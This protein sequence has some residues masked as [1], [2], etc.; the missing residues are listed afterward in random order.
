MFFAFKNRIARILIVLFLAA[1]LVLVGYDQLRR[2]GERLLLQ[3]ASENMEAGNFQAGLQVAHRAYQ[4][5]PD[6]RPAARLMAVML[7]QVEPQAALPWWKRAWELMPDDFEAYTRILT[8]SMNSAPPEEVLERINRAPPGFQEKAEF[9][10]LA[11]LVYL[12]YQDYPR[13]LNA[14][15]RAIELDPADDESRLGQSLIRSQSNRPDEA[16]EAFRQILQ[17]TEPG[18]P[19]EAQA[20]YNL[21]TSNLNARLEPARIA[22][23]TD[24]YLGLPTTDFAKRLEAVRVATRLFPSKKE[25]WLRVLEEEAL[26]HPSR[27]AAYAHTLNHAGDSQRVLSLRSHFHDR[28]REFPHLDTIMLDALILERQWT[29]AAAWIEAISE[30]S[31]T[32]WQQMAL[33]VAGVQGEWQ[34]LDSNLLRLILKQNVSAD[35]L[36][37][38]SARAG[39]HQWDNIQEAALWAR[40]DLRGHEVPALRELYQFYQSRSDGL[41]VLLTS[42]KM[43]QADPASLPAKASSAHLNLCRGTNMTKAHRLAEECYRLK[44][45]SV[46]IRML[47]LLSLHLQGN[48]PEAFALLDQFTPE[49]RRTKGMGLY[50]DY[51]DWISG[52]LPVPPAWDTAPEGYLDLELMLLS[53]LIRE[54]QR[55]GQKESGL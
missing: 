34:R 3:E 12:R 5:N 42:E 46:Q 36:R 31:R 48:S 23:L 35:Q 30:A 16:E 49:E 10:K 8:L 29:E 13:A 55:E 28:R 2:H 51:F 52:R 44:P 14:F 41:G 47:Y 20:L 38:I 9:H 24:R 25:G 19:A 45:E 1:L 37:G 21:I 11:A 4:R 26:R 40:A 43:L 7:E 50:L 6:S 17:A 27:L 39:F 32:P 22:A 53:R 15:A 54:H 33:R 18:H